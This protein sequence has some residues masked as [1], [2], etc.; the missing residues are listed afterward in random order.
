V[1][2]CA[3]QS[4]YL[5]ML[6]TLI[7]DA[8]LLQRLKLTGIVISSMQELQAYCPTCERVSL[9][10]SQVEPPLLQTYKK[11]QSC[12]MIAVSALL[13]KLLGM[14]SSRESGRTTH[15][16][17]KRDLHLCC[18]DSKTAQLTMALLSY[19]CPDSS[20]M[21]GSFSSF[22]VMGHSRSGGGM[23]ER[24]LGFEAI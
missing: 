14:R 12:G 20:S 17:C 11:T 9:S 4:T 5:H 8:T 6:C 22:L 24:S 1:R 13:Q 18:L 3:Q 7:M 2:V 23:L 21:T 16:C 10:A 19:V 15:H